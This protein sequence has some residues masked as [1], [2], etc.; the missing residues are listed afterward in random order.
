MRAG[1]VIVAS[2]LLGAAE[3]EEE[4]CRT[5]RGEVADVSPTLGTL[6]VVEPESNRV[7]TLRVNEESELLLDGKAVSLGELSKGT[8]VRASY[9]VRGSQLV[10]SKVEGRTKPPAKNE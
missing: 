1:V 3:P 10:A 9:S 4:V 5:V 6:Q 8:D 7:L 2:L